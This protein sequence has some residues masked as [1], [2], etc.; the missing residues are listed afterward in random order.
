MDLTISYL[1]NTNIFVQYEQY[2]IQG[3]SEVVRN[4]LHILIC[5]NAQKVMK[6]IIRLTNHAA[7]SQNHKQLT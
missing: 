6:I 4:A 5:M 2:I 7:L 1:S 3:V